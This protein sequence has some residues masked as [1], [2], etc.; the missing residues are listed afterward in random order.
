MIVKR[1]LIPERRRTLPRQGFSWIDRRFVR[2]FA[3]ALSQE[4]LLLYFFL[5]AVS[6][7]D[8]LS[9]YQ[10]HTLAGRLRL[11][12]A[13]IVNARNALIERDLVAFDSPLTQVL[14]LPSQR[15]ER[16]DA[17]RLGEVLN[18]VALAAQ[19]RSQP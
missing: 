13:Q 3:P 15:L 19:Q 10:P 17:Q 11:P 18:A 14:A 6:D 1:L 12:E 8:G 5:A 9:Y 16:G 2:E 7:K 4:A